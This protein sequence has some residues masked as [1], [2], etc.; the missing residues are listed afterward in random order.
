[1]EV[2]HASLFSGIGACEIAAHSLGW[3]NMFNV[4]INPFS[5]QVP[6]FWFPETKGYKDVKTTDFAQ[7]R[8]RITVLSGG[9]PCQGFSLAGQRRGT[10][11]DRYLW[12]ELLRAIHEIQ[13]A[14]VLGENVFGILSMVE[15]GNETSLGIETSL[16]GESDEIL[17]KRQQYVTDIIRE[18]LEREG[19]SLQIFCIPACAVGAPHRRDRVWFIA[20]R[21]SQDTVRGG[22]LDGH[23]GKQEREWNKWDVSAGDTERVRGE[24]PRTITN[25][26]SDGSGGIARGESGTSERPNGERYAEP[27]VNGKVPSFAA[28]DTRGDG[29]RNRIYR[30]ERRDNRKP[31]GSNAEENAKDGLFCEI[32]C[33]G[34]IAANTDGYRNSTS[35]EGGGFDTSGRGDIPFREKR[36]DTPQRFDGLSPISRDAPNTYRTRFQEERPEQ[37]ATRAP[38]DVPL[39]APNA[40]GERFQRRAEGDGEISGET[41]RGEVRGIDRGFVGERSSADPE[42][43]RAGRLQDEGETERSRMRDVVLG[44]CHRLYDTGLPADKFKD[45]PTTFP[46]VRGGDDGIPLVLDSAP[47]SFSKWRAEAVK[48]YGN[49]MCVPV[50]VELF[51]AIQQDIDSIAKQS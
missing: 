39:H 25:S 38:G 18:D 21:V 3:K 22:F 12:P 34:T 41:K 1:M 48:A 20:K 29:F 49:S 37:Q 17:G 2:T 27:L 46:T 33:G 10:E 40:T 11:D 26:T 32:G 23:D 16:F 5:R 19:Y 35:E 36:G 8:G 43:G 6:D 4:E 13:P 47:L 15:P 31:I 14:Y 28:S 30:G 45:F 44:E 7:Y 9:F 50:V 42:G 24:I 51:R